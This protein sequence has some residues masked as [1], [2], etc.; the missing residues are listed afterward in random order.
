MTYFFII[1]WHIF[2]EK[3]GTI[4]RDLITKFARYRQTSGETHDRICYSLVSCRLIKYK[5]INNV[6]TIARRRKWDNNYKRRMT[7]VVKWQRN[8]GRELRTT[9]LLTSRESEGGNHVDDDDD[10]DD[11]GSSRCANTDL[12]T[13]ASLGV[14]PGQRELRGNIYIGAAMPLGSG[15]PGDR[16]VLRETDHGRRSASRELLAGLIDVTRDLFVFCERYKI[17]FTLYQSVYVFHF[18]S[19]YRYL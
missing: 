19:K 15:P 5:R 6:Q 11:D 4:F 14:N 12:S 18:I 2:L 13:R 3:I 17:Y 16:R 9:Y 7:S 1:L 8:Y 10:D